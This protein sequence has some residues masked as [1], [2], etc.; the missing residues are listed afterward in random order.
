MC[1]LVFIDETRKD[2]LT[3]RRLYG[4]GVRGLRT[5][6]EV[7]YS[8]ATRGYSALGVL[9]V[10]GTIDCAI[11]SSSGV[12][13][14]Q[15]VQDFYECAIPHLQPYPA[16]RS[17]VVLDNA[18]AHH[19]PRIAEAVHRVGALIFFLPAYGYD[20][21]PIESAFSKVKAV[22]VRNPGGSNTRNPRAALR[23]ALMSISPSDAAGY[24][25]RCGWQV[26]EGPLAFLGIM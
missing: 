24:F 22:L 13:S 14:E 19:H 1:E 8:R 25:R 5:A 16:P 7:A 11:R 6:V 2:P 17:V 15:C 12:S 10:D 9:T 21:Q 3:E 20:L 4:R 23:R 18:I 26:Q